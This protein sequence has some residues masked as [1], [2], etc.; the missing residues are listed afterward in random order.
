MSVLEVQPRSVP[1]VYEF[2]A[3]AEASHSV[4]VRSL[5]TGTILARYFTEGTNVKRGQKLFLIF[6]TWLNVSMICASSARCNR[7]SPIIT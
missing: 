6:R 1:A 3:Q 2:T 7:I 5:V 4:E